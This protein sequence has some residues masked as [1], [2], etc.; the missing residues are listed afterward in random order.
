M[1]CRSHR[2]AGFRIADSLR[3]LPVASHLA[4]R[5]LCQLLPYFSLKRCTGQRKR[6]RKHL[7]T[8]RKILIELPLRAKKQ[9][10]RSKRYGIGYLFL[11]QNFFDSL[12]PAELSSAFRQENPY[13]EQ[14]LFLPCL[15]LFSAYCYFFRPNNFQQKENG[16]GF[17][18]SFSRHSAPQL[19]LPSPIWRWSRISVTCSSFLSSARWVALVSCSWL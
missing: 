8:S 6:Q 18:R 17:R 15:I 14:P 9:F 11:E 19:A 16:S 4:V 1:V 2:P 12:P 7:S 5:D 3:N 10:G 13:K